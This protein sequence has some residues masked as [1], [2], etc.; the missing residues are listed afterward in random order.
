VE[1]IEKTQLLTKKSLENELNFKF[2]E[3]NLL[4]TFHSVTL[5]NEPTSKQFKELLEVLSELEDTKIIF[6]K[7]NSDDGNDEIFELIDQYVSCH[8]NAISF[9]SLG[10]LRYLSMLQFVDGVVGNSSS[11]I[12]EATSFRIGTINIGDRQKG[13][14]HGKSVI[15]CMCTRDDI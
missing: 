1:N 13:R 15:D 14:I 7:P 10:M 2:S 11:G 8:E 4:V 9:A 6:T 12:I 3:K 5:E